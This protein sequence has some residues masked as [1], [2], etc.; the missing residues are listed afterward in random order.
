[1]QK[2][3]ITTD[4]SP[5]KDEVIKRGLDLARKLDAAVDLVTVVNN[6]IDF[7]PL[8]YGMGVNERWLARQLYAEQEL[9]D[10]KAAYPDLD[11][12]VVVFVG[13]PKMEILDHAIERNASVIV[14]GTHG[15]TGIANWVM[16]STAEFIVR[17]S[18]VP[19]FVIPYNKTKH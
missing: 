19:V 18:P 3:I 11:I 9:T 2:V 1:M 5:M 17:H 13:D 6:Q 8:D 4:L 12:D 16:G 15:R 10:V 7:E 14:M